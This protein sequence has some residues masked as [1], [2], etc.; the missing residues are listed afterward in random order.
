MTKQDY[1]RKMNQLAEEDGQDTLE[2]VEKLQQLKI[3][4]GM[5]DGEVALFSHSNEQAQGSSVIHQQDFY[6]NKLTQS[7]SEPEVGK[8]LVKR[9]QA[10]R[11]DRESRLNEL[12]LR[13][14]ERKFRREEEVGEKIRQEIEERHQ[15]KQLKLE[16]SISRIK[17]RQLKNDT[18][19]V[20]SKEIASSVYLKRSSIPESQQNINASR[21]VN[22]EQTSSKIHLS[23]RIYEESVYKDKKAAPLSVKS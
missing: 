9:L 3:Q 8:S 17:N 12:R 10:E 1:L 16:Q 15:E 2:N 6:R 11:K 7:P 14:Q 23:P 22:L 4:F 18:G 20:F 21:I 5:I 19:S 13:E